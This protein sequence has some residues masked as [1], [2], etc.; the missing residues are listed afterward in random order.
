MTQHA[1][2]C[3]FPGTFCNFARDDFANPTK[4]ELARL[5]VA[6]HLFAMFRSCAFRNHH[7]RSQTTSSLARLN[8]PSNL[9]V[10]EW[11]FRNQ[12]DIGA[13]CDAAMQRDPTGMASHHFDYHH[14]PVAG[15][16]SVQS[17]ERIHHHINGRIESER[18]R[19]RFKVVVDRFGD[20]DAIDAGFL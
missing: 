1:A 11:D 13:A 14:S 4:P 5:N 10:I 7:D 6:L 19:R 2:A 3:L 12:N 18:Y 17:V 15:R 16:G 9:V 8:Y 20:T